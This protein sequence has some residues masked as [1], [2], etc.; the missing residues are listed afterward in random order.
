MR[1]YKWVI[2]LMLLCLVLSGC[3]KEKHKTLVSAHTSIGELLI[4]TKTQADLLHNQKIISDGR[5]G[6]IRVNW[7][8]AQTSFITASDMLN[9]IIDSKDEDA[10]MYLSLLTEINTIL[11]DIASWIEEERESARK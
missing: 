6:E 9:K 11:M 8:R 4:T 3:V 5:Y 1:K 10:S 7:L 2:G